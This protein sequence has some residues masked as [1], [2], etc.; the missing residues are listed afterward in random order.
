MRTALIGITAAAILLLRDAGKLD[1]DVP[2]PVPYS[3]PEV[4]A[5]ARRWLSDAIAGKID[6][7][8]LRPAARAALRRPRIQ[9]ALRDLAR[10]SDRTYTLV[11]VDRRRSKLAYRHPNRTL[12]ALPLR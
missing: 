9:A 1:V 5:F 4:G 7:A 6:F 2:P 8:K 11:N 10:F 3:K 12:V